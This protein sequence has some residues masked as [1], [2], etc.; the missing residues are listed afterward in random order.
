MNNVD[1]LSIGRLMVEV[2]DVGGQYLLTWAMPC[3]PFAGAQQGFFVLPSLESGVWVEFEQGDTD[4][5]IWTR[6]LLRPGTGSGVDPGDAAGSAGSGD[7]DRRAEHA[8][9]Q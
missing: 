3:F 7:P 9:N 2:L 4:Y 8:G 5:P 1:P 6:L